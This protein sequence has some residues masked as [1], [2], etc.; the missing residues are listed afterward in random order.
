MKPHTFPTFFPLEKT[1]FRDQKPTNRNGQFSG[2]PEI[3]VEDFGEGAYWTVC[4]I[5]MF[6]LLDYLSLP[7]R[8][9]WGTGDVENAARIW[10]S[11]IRLLTPHKYALIGLYNKKLAATLQH[12]DHRDNSTGPQGY[13][14]RTQLTK[15]VERPLPHPAEQQF[16]WMDTG[17]CSLSSWCRTIKRIFSYRQRMTEYDVK[18]DCSKVSNAKK[19]FELALDIIA[20][21]QNERRNDVSPYALIRALLSRAAQNLPPRDKKAYLVD[22]A[23]EWGFPNI[24]KALKESQADFDAGEI[25]FPITLLAQMGHDMARQKGTTPLTI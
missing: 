3:L 8:S 7:D 10:D 19:Y 15:R 16:Q 25:L 22:A 1:S 20:S 13:R 17:L 5:P 18:D 24:S 6:Q 21:F 9:A 23:L 14:L 4:K 2:G 12:M 11:K